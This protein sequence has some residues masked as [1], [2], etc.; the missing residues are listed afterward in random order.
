MDTDKRQIPSI[1][2][3]YSTST[4]GWCIDRVAKVVLSVVEAE[5]AP[6]SVSIDEMVVWCGGCDGD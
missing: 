5:T 6:G 2:D 1:N 4:A 3:A